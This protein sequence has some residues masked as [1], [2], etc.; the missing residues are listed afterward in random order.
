MR[1]A[2]FQ[3]FA[4]DRYPAVG[5]VREVE[6]WSEGTAR[7][8]G[9]LV[10][11]D[12]GVRLWQAVTAQPAATAEPASGPPPAPVPQPELPA[13]R[14]TPVAIERFLVAAVANAGRA[15]M[16]RV[17]GYSDR[18]PP[19][20]TPGLAVEFH[21]GARIFAPFVHLAGPQQQRGPA[22]ELPQEV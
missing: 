1:P 17:W 21:S 20:S 9:L 18:E 3:E 14:M 13:G 10:T 11:F 12:S 15:E 7:P 6:P 5:G 22:Y 2:S 8:F 16:A 19:A 4:R